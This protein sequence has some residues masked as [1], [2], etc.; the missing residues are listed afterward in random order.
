[1]PTES[2]SRR[3]RFSLLTLLLLMAIAAMGIVIWQLWSEVEPLRAEVR[4]LRL[5]TGRLTID[6]PAK[7]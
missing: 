5:E 2:Q 1:M 4:N 7:A 6:D 3:P